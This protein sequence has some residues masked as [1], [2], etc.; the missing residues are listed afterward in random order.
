VSRR[1]SNSSYQ[2]S[3]AIKKVAVS[4]LSPDMW[5]V[6]CYT[7]T[8]PHT[9][10]HT[11]AYTRIRARTYSY[12]LMLYTRIRARTV[13]THTYSYILMLYTRAGS[14]PRSPT[15]PRPMMMMMMMMYTC[16]RRHVFTFRWA[17]IHRCTSMT[18]PPPCRHVHVCRRP[19]S[20]CTYTAYTHTWRTCSVR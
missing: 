10:T 6:A 7:A 14:Q 12:I 16:I 2:I 20:D 5:H 11:H 19:V 17:S 15:A 8:P 9:N 3:K 13:R 1:G 4:P 18:R